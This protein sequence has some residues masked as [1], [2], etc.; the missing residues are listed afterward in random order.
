MSTDDI[1][2]HMP[3][4]AKRLLAGK[5]SSNAI[6]YL[7]YSDNPKLNEIL[8]KDCQTIYADK[9]NS[10]DGFY[11]IFGA[12]RHM[13]HLPGNSAGYMARKPAWIAG[14]NEM[15]IERVCE[16]VNWLE[17]TQQG[18]DDPILFEGDEFTVTCNPGIEKQLIALWVIRKSYKKP[19]K[20]K[21][22]I[23]SAV[24][25]VRFGKW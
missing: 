8:L 23:R 1:D 15:E 6:C 24:Q 3:F 12:V 10:K 22:N 11:I 7:T 20:Q 17:Q 16:I 4:P 2:W 19:F 9:I 14:L 5:M 18:E 13:V 25:A 21:S